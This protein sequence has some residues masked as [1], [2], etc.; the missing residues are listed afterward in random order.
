MDDILPR[1]PISV[2]VPPVAPNIESDR[3]HLRPITDSDIPAL[4]AIRSRPEVARSKY[5]IPLATI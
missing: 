5:V 2:I 1:Q 4:F 3:L